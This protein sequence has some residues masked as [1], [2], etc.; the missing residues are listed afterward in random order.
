MENINLDIYYEQ[1]EEE[2]TEK[3]FEILEGKHDNLLI[4]LEDILEKK[5]ILKGNKL[6]TYELLSYI[7]LKLNKPIEAYYYGI[8][9]F[10]F[11]KNSIGLIFAATALIK[12]NKEMAPRFIV[13]YLK[14]I[15]DTFQ[16][17]K[18]NEENFKNDY[19]FLSLKK[20]IKFIKEDLKLK[21]KESF[22]FNNN[23][24]FYKFEDSFV[25]IK[26]YY[27][28]GLSN[29][30]LIKINDEYLILDCGAEI[31]NDSIEKIDIDEFLKDIPKEKIKGVII[32]HAH[33]DH[34][35]SLD[36]IYKYTDNIY[37]G[38]DTC[39]LIELV[40]GN[41]YIKQSPKICKSYM[42]FKLGNYVITP[43]PNG[44]I[45]GS[46]AFYIKNKDISLFYTGDFC[47]NNQNTVPGLKK[48]NLEM[49]VKEKG[50][51]NYLIT[52]STYGNKDEWLTYSQRKFLLKYFI[53]LSYKNS[54]KV[55]IPSFAIGRA[56][57]CQ[58][59]I[60]EE[61]SMYAL[62]DGLA[63]KVTNYYNQFSINSNLISKKTLMYPNS[64]DILTKYKK[65]PIIIA[66]SGMLKNDSIAMKYYNHI[67]QDKMTTIIKCGYMSEKVYLNKFF[68]YEGRNIN[69]IDINLSAHA[70]YEELL[71]LINL[72]KPD[73]LVVVHG[74]GIKGITLKKS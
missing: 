54:V 43:I 6:E 45:L 27:S 24:G 7:K 55:F 65:S 56:Q 72:V 20:I 46:M 67:I 57:E 64:C 14:E 66:S 33:L 3:S 58:A 69:V 22:N 4:M 31:K 62:I 51:I 28:Q 37:M 17:S 39:N 12:I 23:I 60:N 29:M 53:N 5:F 61:D 73:N 2:I 16:S 52:E 47:F 42:D 15:E 49:L 68:N 25:K 13:R 19:E 71:D 35:G 32:S 9:S 11:S 34:Y 41:T 1:L 36:K 40:T 21:S 38:Y 50:R 18:F 26:S 30:H 70:Q 59:I 63:K 74:E 48:K 10:R 8:E 44:H